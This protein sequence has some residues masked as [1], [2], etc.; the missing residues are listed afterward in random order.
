MISI[1]RLP[2]S[3][4]ITCEE[5]EHDAKVRFA[6]S[7]NKLT[8]FVSA[9]SS[10]VKFLDL[11]W[12]I[13]IRE[14]VSVMGDA[15][16]RTYADI[17]FTGLL[18]ERALPWYFALRHKGGT[19]CVGVGVQPNALIYFNIDAEGVTAHCDLRS[20]TVGVELAGR[21]IAVADFMSAEYNKE[22]FYALCDFCKKMCPDPILPKEKIYGGNNWYYAYGKSS[23]E[24][25]LSDCALQA[26]LAEGLENPPFMVIDDG[27]QVKH[28][29][30]PWTPNEKFGDMK[31]IADAFKAMG[32][33]PGIWFRPLRDESES[34]PAQ[35]RF[36]N[37]NQKEAE[38]LDPSHPGV[39]AH[40][41][42]VVKTMV[43]WG[44]EL[45][46]HDFSSFDIFGAWGFERKKHLSE[47]DW[48]FYDSSKTSAEI[49]KNFL[50][51]LLDATEG[52]AYLIGCNCISHLTAGLSHI[53][54][55]GD[56]T[57]GKE[58]ER[59]R[60]YGINTLAFRLCQNNAF[61]VVDADCAGFKDGNIPFGLNKKW[62][63]LLAKSGTPMFVSAPAGAFNDEEKAFLKEMYKIASLQKN[64][65]A[66]VDY[67]YNATPALWSIDGEICEF[68]WWNE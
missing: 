52:K 25:I 56:D 7:D 23:C 66:P 9:A 26:E 21:E 4:Q 37:R 31:K 28:L 12:N 1:L 32:V 35:W 68:D 60:S 6:L 15:W 34:I 22:P 44:Y 62:V 14:E 24:E 46:K 50:K 27:W 17:G 57:S 48:R 58:W 3:A 5:K 16:E 20:G 2:D 18:A 55:V 64:V 41:S 65:T 30:G 61:Y 11:R 54:R 63:E 8:V 39:L 40:I 49:Y 43:G 47:G 29:Q 45:I 67:L 13:K 36:K 51:T 53:N 38:Y 59:T 33:R 42:S 10:R 19:D